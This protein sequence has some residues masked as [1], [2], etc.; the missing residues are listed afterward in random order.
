[1]TQLGVTDLRCEYRQAPLAVDARRPRLSWK[2]TA[3]PGQQNVR[4]SAYRILVASSAED[5]AAG[6]GDLWDSGRVE[7][8]QSVLLEYSGKALPSR[9]RCHWQ[10]QVWDQDGRESAWSASAFWQMGLLG[11]KDWRAQWIKSAAKMPS[12]PPYPVPPSPVLRRDFRVKKPVKSATAYVCGLGYFELRLNGKKVGDHVLDPAFSRYDRRAL[13]VGLD[14]TSQLREGANA[15]GVMLG[16]GWYNCHTKEVWQFESASWRDVPKL[17][18]QLH[19]EYLDGTQD[20]VCSDETWKASTGPI[21]FDGLRNGEVY[22]ARNET[23]GWDQPG[24]DDSA[25]A[26]SIIAAGPGGVL[27]AQPSEPCRVTATIAPVS[28]KEVRP[29]VWVYDLGQNFAGWAQLHV[30]G[31]AGAE[32][33]LK[34]AEKIGP[35]GDIDQ[36]NIEWFIK[37]GECQTDKYTLKGEGEETWEPRFTYHGFR[38]VQMTGF[39]G[40][41]TLANLRG[42]VVGTD[43]PEA[44]GF[45]CSDDLLNRIQTCTK[46]AYVSN[47]VGIPT[48]CPHREKNGWTGDA[49]LACETGLLNYDSASG[50][51][52]WL[53][54]MRDEQR[55]NGALPGIVP[56]GGWGYNWGNGPAWD[57]AAVLIPWYLYLYRGDAR[58]LAQQ[59]ETMRRYVD[60]MTTL[61]TKHIVS[62]GLGDWCDPSMDA[63]NGV[64]CPSAVTSTGYYF[65]D[66]LVLAQTAEILGKA[67]DARKYR[68][69]AGKI[70]QAFN[71]TFYQGAGRFDA[72]GQTTPACALYQG[73]VEPGEKAAVVAELVNRIEAKGGKLDFGILGAKYVLNALAD[74][75]QIDVAFAFATQRTEPSWG[76]WLDQ[77]ATTLWETW[78]GKSSRN[79]IM[80]GDISAW[81]IKH[82]AGINPDPAQPGFKH[83]IIRPRPVAALTW[84]KAWHETPYGR[85][86]SEW[87]RVNG[88]LALEV[89]VPPN[90]TATVHVPSGESREVGS[91]IWT[92]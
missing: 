66:S 69:L 25:W 47:F 26:E 89:E 75:G 14:V 19:I 36:K 62:Y 53:E 42:C 39:P 31:P 15:L 80:F 82:L 63:G 18:L 4:Q 13:Y 84:V 21:V 74:E 57:S 68:A 29:G 81:M 88:K 60:Y 59:Y 38:W 79:H 49:V 28:M 85:V 23:P 35:D 52:K 73:L 22:D 77:G 46:W 56:T 65:V 20:V 30:S 37:S 71:K 8:A 40:T 83:I 3:A 70:R 44:G 11:P 48:D 5:L 61:A 17:F 43:F 12:S 54:D 16:H 50:Y 64:T 32:I 91:G 33:T 67:S 1:M 72:A 24:F 45:A 90:T 2:I 87:R 27:S 6:Q 10:V 34:Y 7:S 58:I 9:Q 76:W 78:H 55:P 41:P 92:W 51:T 86:R